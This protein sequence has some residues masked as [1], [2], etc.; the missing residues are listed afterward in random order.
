MVSGKRWLEEVKQLASL[1]K[2]Y[3]SS[4]NSRNSS[5]SSSNNDKEQNLPHLS[6]QMTEAT[7]PRY[8]CRKIFH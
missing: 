8:F 2:L 1:T 5:S 6:R 4:S 3:S 7:L